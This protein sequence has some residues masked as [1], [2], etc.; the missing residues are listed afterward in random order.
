[1]GKRRRAQLTKAEKEVIVR[2]RM[3]EGW[4]LVRIAREYER[5]VQTIKNVVDRA[6]NSSSQQGRVKKLTKPEK[7]HILS[8]V[9]ER[10]RVSCNELHQE[11][12]LPSASAG[13]IRLYLLKKGYRCTN[14]KR[15]P[16][17]RKV[18]E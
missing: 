6:N 1:M 2:L 12:A 5:S 15:K 7:M 3:G 10:P 8:I 13:T 18:G 16:L 9:Q 14:P 17:W 11:L 4:N